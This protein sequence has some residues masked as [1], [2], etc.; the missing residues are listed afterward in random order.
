MMSDD[1]KQSGLQMHLNNER[2]EAL[3]HALI[4]RCFYR[5]SA[6]SNEYIVRELYAAPDHPHDHAIESEIGLYENVNAD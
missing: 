3:L 5:E 1:A 6:L 4:Q 2:F